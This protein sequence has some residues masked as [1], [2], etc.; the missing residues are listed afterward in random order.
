MQTTLNKSKNSEYTFLIYLFLILCKS[1]T[2][3]A[4]FICTPSVCTMYSV[5]VNTRLLPKMSSTA[6]LTV[7]M[8]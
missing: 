4:M 7:G 1:R 3:H 2:M 6:K 8:A 5:E